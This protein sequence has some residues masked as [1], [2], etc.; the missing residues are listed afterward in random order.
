MGIWVD[1]EPVGGGRWLTV[2]SGTCDRRARHRLLDEARGLA[3]I[4]ASEVDVSVA[5]L[6]DMD[7]D[8]ARAIDEALAALNRL[9]V[10]TTIGGALGQAETLLA[11]AADERDHRG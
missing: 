6:H 7:T 3:L 4:G 10:R 1:S 8:G 5:G 11:L 9:G 2:L